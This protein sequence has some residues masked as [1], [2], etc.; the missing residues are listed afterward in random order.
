MR[1]TTC[2]GAVKVGTLTPPL[3]IKQP[4]WLA[5]LACRNFVDLLLDKVP[6]QD[7]H[8]DQDHR[9]CEQLVCRIHA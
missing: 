1:S 2:V 7:A 5:S 9:E 3:L 8:S 4:V 6:D